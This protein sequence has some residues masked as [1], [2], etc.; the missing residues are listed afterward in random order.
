MNIGIL[1]D[2]HANPYSLDKCLK[3]FKKFNVEKIF[4]LGD[5]IGYFTEPGQVLEKLQLINAVC[6]MGNH[7]AMLLGH[8]GFD[9]NKDEIYKITES[10]SK[11]SPVQ[12]RE[13]YRL[14][15]FYEETID[16]RR[17]L[18]VHGSPWNPI[19]GYIYPGD[20]LQKFANLPFDVVFMGHTHRPFISKL[21][22]VLVVN[23]GSCSLS[24]DDGRLLSCAIYDT[25]KG[26]CQILRIPIDVD[27]VI[28]FYENIHQSVI[29]CLQ[30]KS[31]KKP[32]TTQVG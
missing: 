3:V 13:M 5:S 8:V 18:F 2:A 30:C 16:N 9:K 1:S 26:N 20:D 19:N 24:R 15:P 11:I 23:V 32:L 21:N 29:N 17:I 10:L 12:L 14:L 7:E 22:N 6:L 25:K 4:H 27:Y 31:E 28:R